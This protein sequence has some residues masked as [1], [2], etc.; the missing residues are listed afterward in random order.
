M[1]DV[2]VPVARPVKIKINIHRLPALSKPAP[3]IFRCTVCYDDYQPSKLVRLPCKDLYCTNCLKNLFLLSTNDQSLFPPK[4][5]GQVI[6][7]F[8]ISGKMTPQQLDSFSNAEIEFSTVDRTYCSNT[9][10]NRFLHPRQV[11]SDRAG[12]THC[13]SVTCTI[14]KKPAHRDDCPEDHDL[15]ATLALALNE[16]WQRCFACRAIVELDTG[17]NHMTCNC[18]AQFCYLCGEKWGTCSCEGDE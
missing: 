11:T 16:K 1:D 4:C 12:C 10:C 14:C 8:L 5:H 6:P 13:G 7:S 9:E 15:Q 2:D 18:G 3:A 17:C